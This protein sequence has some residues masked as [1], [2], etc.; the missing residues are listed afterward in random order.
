MWKVASIVMSIVIVAI[1]LLFIKQKSDF[2]KTKRDNPSYVSDSLIVYKSFFDLNLTYSGQ[3]IDD[4][5]CFF[6]DK[7]VDLSELVKDKPVL[8]L[9][10]SSTTCSACLEDL[11]SKING[12]V[13]EMLILC[14][15][16]SKKNFEILTRDM[17][18]KYPICRVEEALFKWMPDTSN[19]PYLL[20]I[21]KDL[22]VSDFFIPD[23]RFLNV[24]IKYLD[25]IESKIR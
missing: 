12:N 4:I 21:N 6:D 5:T 19:Q 10:H 1:V 8:V 11:L 3:K 2:S 7:E 18:V 17:N 16:I 24:T 25:V 9:M 22:T 13:D 15:D 14:S 20:V 23:S